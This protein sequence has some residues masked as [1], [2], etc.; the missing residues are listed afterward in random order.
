[1]LYQGA[2]DEHASTSRPREA[3]AAAALRPAEVSYA[4]L[5][6]GPGKD[7]VEVAES[8]R[9]RIHGAMVEI[10]A[11][12]GYKAVTVR[13]LARRARISSRAFY[14]HFSG[15]EDCFLRTHEAI[16]RRAAKR[17]IASQAGERDW[18]QRLRLASQAFARELAR[19]PKAAR[20]ALV[21]AY[22]AG[23]R[24]REQALWAEGIF[25]AMLR[26]SF[27]RVLD[28]VVVSPLVT[29][30]LVAGIASVARSRVLWGEDT[31]QDADDLGDALAE[32]LLCCRE[33]VG[34]SKELAEAGAEPKAP[35][36]T[37]R[38]RR[39]GG[40][41][42]G[43]ER[44]LILA[45]T[46]KLVA[47]EG[48]GTLTLSRI[49]IATGVSRKTLESHFGGIEDCVVAAAESRA[50]EAFAYAGEAKASARTWEEGVHLAVAALC[51]YVA[52]DPIL[53]T[54]CFLEVASLGQAGLHCCERFTAEIA[55]LI[56][57]GSPNDQC[58]DEVA[59]EASAGAI[60]GLMGQLVLC[61]RRKHL[62]GAAATL[63]S[64]ALAPS[65]ERLPVPSLG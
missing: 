20:L 63:A 2:E 25:A 23:P 14:Q 45:A 65:R 3:S 22:G 40:R 32:W 24:A 7:A 64:L 48:Y 44:D 56:C 53:A 13:D 10:V 17:V 29:R 57:Y 30:G 8:Q 47:T 38:R 6:P 27:D 26:E 34:G 36:G 37:E 55:D 12:R 62:P 61:G 21:E 49:R 5:S 18:Q 19:D 60:W 58:P 54:L 41:S 11:E 15:K 46:A 28:G 1:M 52:E 4:K 31:E 39:G 59:T 35:L 51:E 16:V 33:Q 50:D 42:A 9:A 43:G